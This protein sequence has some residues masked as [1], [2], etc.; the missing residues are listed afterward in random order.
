M[1][2][3][4]DLVRISTEP[5]CQKEITEFVTDPSSGAI[6]I[7]LGEQIS[8]YFGVGNG[9]DEMG[10][11]GWGWG[12]GAWACEDGNGN[13]GNVGMGMGCGW[14]VHLPTRSICLAQEVRGGA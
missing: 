4:A 11:G 5:L 13:H 3:D 14:V 7:F 12:W 9:G 1:G 8:E 2:S 6:S 10:G